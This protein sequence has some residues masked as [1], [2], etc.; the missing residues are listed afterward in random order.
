MFNLPEEL[1]NYIYLFDPTFH[2]QWTIV[3]KDLSE[4]KY[5]YFS[6][7]NRY[8]YYV[9]CPKSFTFHMTNSLLYPNYICTT[10][11][12]NRF[13]LKKLIEFYSL[14]ENKHLKVNYDIENNSGLPLPLQM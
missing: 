2:Q 1:Q 11:N 9:Y 12:V 14:Q 4:Y 3:N 10:Y 5:F 13:K 8:I 7:L 6:S